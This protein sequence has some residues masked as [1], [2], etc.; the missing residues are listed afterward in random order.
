MTAAAKR[1][2][3]TCSVNLNAGGIFLWKTIRPAHI[4]DALDATLLQYPYYTARLILINS[5]LVSRRTVRR[6]WDLSV[7]L[8]L[9]HSHHLSV[10]LRL[11]SLPLSFSVLTHI[12]I[13]HQD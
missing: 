5:N 3:L 8:P 6:E 11:P 7:Y 10:G 12:H 4:Q 2:P 1:P 13:T 9:C